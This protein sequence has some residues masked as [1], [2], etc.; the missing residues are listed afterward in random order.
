MLLNVNISFLGIM[1]NKAKCAWL[2]YLIIYTSVARV[3]DGI[4]PHPN[5]GGPC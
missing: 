3:S 2:L 1:L 4:V 5:Q